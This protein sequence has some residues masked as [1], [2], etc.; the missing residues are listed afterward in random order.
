MTKITDPEDHQR[1][2]EI[3]E[4]LKS[5]LPPN[6]SDIVTNVF[7]EYGC[8][9][10]TIQ[11]KRYAIYK[12]A[13]GKRD[14]CG[15][16]INEIKDSDLPDICCKIKNILFFKEPQNRFKTK[17][18]VGVR[19]KNDMID[20]STRKTAE[21]VV[22]IKSPNS[23]PNWDWDAENDYRTCNK[24]FACFDHYEDIPKRLKKRLVDMELTTYLMRKY[25]LQKELKK[26]RHDL[27]E[28][29]AILKSDPMQ[30]MPADLV[31]DYYKAYVKE[32]V[33]GNVVTI[34][35]N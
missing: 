21:D 1:I 3:Q 18:F 30:S 25:E 19:K 14:K 10:V 27:K 28:A 12:W 8:A 6:F 11:D 16:R 33:S 4:R 32:I 23:N 31:E 26:C 20:F 22:V 29:N 13:L 35:V 15:M 7:N 17:T 2:L 5:R 34:K 24:I 9:S